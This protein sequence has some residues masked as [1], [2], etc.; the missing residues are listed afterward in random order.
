[1][2]SKTST[3][4]TTLQWARILSSAS[5]W[6]LARSAGAIL[7]RAG[8]S[9]TRPFPAGERPAVEE[10]DEA[11]LPEALGDDR[12]HP[13]LFAGVGLERFDAAED[14]IGFVAREPALVRRLFGGQLEQGRGGRLA[15]GRI[16]ERAGQEPEGL[17]LADGRDAVDDGLLVGVVERL[18][19]EVPEEGELPLGRHVRPPDEPDVAVEGQEAVALARGRRGDAEKVRGGLIVGPLGQGVDRGGL[20]LEVG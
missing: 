6:A 13:G 14:R 19:Q 12:R 11:A 15:E 8:G 4:S 18:G 5:A 1:M 3:P 20:D 2:P 10:R 7:A 16:V 9:A 17:G